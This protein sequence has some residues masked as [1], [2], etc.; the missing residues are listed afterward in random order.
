VALEAGDLARNRVLIGAQYLAHLFWVE[1]PREHR[2]ADEV[3]EHH[4]ELAPLGL[5]RTGQLPLMTRLVGRFR[6]DVFLC[7]I[8][9]A[10]ARTQ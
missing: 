3:D 9:S 7:L 10:R 4:R 2:R 6:R 1:M 8:R 5:S